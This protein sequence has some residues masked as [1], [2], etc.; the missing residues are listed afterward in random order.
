MA[1]GQALAGINTTLTLIPS[2][3]YSPSTSTSHSTT[4][5]STIDPNRMSALQQTGGDASP[6]DIRT[7]TKL[8]PSDTDA[9]GTA[10]ADM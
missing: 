9:Q 8:T 5:T 10:L 2:A 4:P 3:L 1:K 6:S 7:V